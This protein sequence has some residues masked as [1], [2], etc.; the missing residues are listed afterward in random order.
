MLG[1]NINN[2]FKFSPNPNLT[3]WNPLMEIETILDQLVGMYG[4]PMPNALLQND[5]HFQSV[6]S[7]KNAPGILF[8]RIKDCQEIQILGDN[9]YTPTQ[10]LNNVI[11]LL[12]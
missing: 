5:T 12:L 4:R 10:L 9:P 1:G 6:Y 3:G 8:R 7:P 2:A 11:Q